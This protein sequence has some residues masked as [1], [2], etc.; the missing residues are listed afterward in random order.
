MGLVLL[1]I[2]PVSTFYSKENIKFLVKKIIDRR[3]GPDAVVA[4]LMRGLRGFNIDF[5]LNPKLSEINSNDYVWVNGSL[6][7]LRW[8]IAAKRSGKIC[9]LFVGPIMV[10]APDEGNWILLDEAIDKIIF[11]STWTRDYYASFDERYR[12]KI[13]I[14]PAGVEAVALNKRAKEDS[15][16]ILLK[17]KEAEETCRQ[18]VDYY[19]EKSVKYDLIKY[20][21]FTQGE[22]FDL[23][24]KA[25]YLVYLSNSESQ[26]VALQEAW[27]RDV[28]TLVWNRGYFEY[29]DH[30]WYN[31]KISAPYLTEACGKF[32]KTFEEFREHI[33]IF[34]SSE[35]NP[36]GYANENL[37]DKVLTKKFL[38]II[39]YVK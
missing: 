35:F 39:N 29:R 15:V 22:Y 9:K 7:A 14:C 17:N 36:H 5:K 30:K 23:L 31:D 2:S 13:A 19:T 20:G 8:A 21:H 3:R 12:E 34:D 24:N 37:T 27:I 25:C 10:I 28:P 18:I 26:G 6:P 38:E 11:P 1:T 4:S 32:F 16:L 33:S